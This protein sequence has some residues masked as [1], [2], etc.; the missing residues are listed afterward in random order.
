MVAVMIKRDLNRIFALLWQFAQRLDSIFTRI[1]QNELR[2]RGGDLKTRLEMIDK[3]APD[4]VSIR[5]KEFPTKRANVNTL[6]SYITQLH[7]YQ[8][9]T[10]NVIIIDYLELLVTDADMAEY[11]AQER[12]AQELR[13][14]AIEHECLVWTATQTNRE[15][16]KV[17]L[18]TDTELAD[19]Y[20]KTRVCDLV[21]SVNQ[22]E[23]EFD[24][25]EARAYIIKSRNGQARF[26]IPVNMDY[27]RLVISQR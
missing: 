24:K 27:Q 3:Q 13:G 19:S 22:T 8:E 17:S 12:L 7:N 1:R 25:G 9:F 15:G 2:D 10:P 5:I 23:E 21:F 16:K 18:I 20:G 14:L 26:V 11:Q 6:R 4:K